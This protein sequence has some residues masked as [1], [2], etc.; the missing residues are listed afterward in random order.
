MPH[1]L[2]ALLCLPGAEPRLSSRDLVEAARA[3]RTAIVTA[4]QENQR[5]AP[6]L[7]RTKDELTAY[8]A[9]AAARAA[10][11]LP[12]DRASPAFL[13]ALGVALDSSALLRENPVTGALWKQVETGAERT[14]RLAVL[15]EPTVHGRHDLC[16]HFVVSCALTAANGPKAAEAAGILKELLDANGGSGFSFADLA[17]DLSGVA[18]GERMLKGPEQLA[19]VEKAFSVADLVVSPKGLVEGLTRAEFEKR[20][21]S[22]SDPRFREALE[23][24]K[25]RVKALPG[26]RTE[27]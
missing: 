8:Y 26:Y 12:A 2:L 24:L 3:V 13:L 18:F 15:G 6:P 17:A 1:L 11:S 19:R 10:R 21:G 4:A 25:A 20:Y 7:R 5:L 16:Q 27:P 22:L 9:Q 14:A 23:A